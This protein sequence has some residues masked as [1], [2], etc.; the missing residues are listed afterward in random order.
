METTATILHADLDAFYA[1][2]EQLLDPSLRGKPIAVGGG[3]VLAASYEAKA[4]GV[5]GGM[6][7]RRA[8]ELCPQ[9]HLRRRPFQGVPAARRRRDRRARRLHAAGRA[10]LHRRGLRRRRRLHAS[11]RPAGRDRRSDPAPRAGGARPADLGRRGA[12]QAPGEDRLAGGQARRAGGRRSRDRARVPAR[13]AGRADVGRRPGHQG[14][15]GRD[16]RA[17]HRA[18]GEDAGWSLERLL[19]RAA[20]EKLAALAW[21][22]DPREIRTQRRAHSAGA[23]S[24]LGRK[25]AE[26]RV[27]RPTLRHLAD[28]VAQPAAGQIA[29]RPHR[30]GARALRRSALGHA[31][32]DARRA[33]LGDRDPRRDRRGSGARACWPITRDER[34]ISLLAI[35]VSHLEEH[36]VLQLELPLGLADEER[37]PGTRRGMARWV[38]D[39]AVDTIRDRFGWEAVGYGV[40]RAGRLALGARRVPRAGREGA[41]SRQRPQPRTTSDLL[42]GARSK[43]CVEVGRYRNVGRSCT[44]I[45]GQNVAWPNHIGIKSSW[46]TGFCR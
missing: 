2:V 46:R 29:A 23:Q 34:T 40:G 24:A 28:R 31:L 3:V 45:G 33:D 37:R 1:S 12:H 25:P 6:P 11:L 7:G 22:R 43:N 26:E 39:R 5:R 10:H 41:V 21:N 8:R 18:A 14:A 4:F 17:H 19:G 13:P 32:D 38:A 16:R 9:L 44:A 35:S 27:F 42:R 15:A 30:D 36:S 20:G